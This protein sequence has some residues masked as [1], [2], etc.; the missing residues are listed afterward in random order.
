MRSG[1]K[2]A[3]G[4]SEVIDH[5]GLV[6]VELLPTLSFVPVCF[7]PCPPASGVI[8]WL[9]LLHIRAMNAASS[10]HF[11]VQGAALI[12]FFYM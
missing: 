11:T 10:E 2:M 12:F 5:L 3:H 4:S 8:F 9:C 1:E 6:Q 7:F